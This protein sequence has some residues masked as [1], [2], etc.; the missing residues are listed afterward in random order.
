LYL[1]A[2]INKKELEEEQPRILITVFAKKKKSDLKNP[3]LWLVLSEN[4]VQRESEVPSHE[5]P[6]I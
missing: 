4:V 6:F 5:S 3:L 2:R 1:H